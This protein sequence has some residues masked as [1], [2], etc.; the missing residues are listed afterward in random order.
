VATEFNYVVNVDQSRVQSS[1]VELASTMQMALA[2][3]MQGAQLQAP[4]AGTTVSDVAGGAATGFNMMAG[5]FSRFP[6][7]MGGMFS[8]MVGGTFTNQA[9]AYTPHWGMQQAE[10]SLQQEWLVDR[11]GLGAAQRM[12]PPGVGATEFALAV[13]RNFVDRKL[14]AEHAA[15]A[16]ARTTMASGV[17]GIAGMYGGGWIGGAIGKMIGA[18][19]GAPGLGKI[20]GDLVGAIA[21]E[22]LASDLATEH[23][24][25]IEQQQGIMTEL[26]E[27]AGGGLGYTRAQRFAFGAAATEA[28]RSLGMDVQ[29][30]GDIVAGARQMGML[31]SS[32]TSGKATPQQVREDLFNLARSIEEGAEALHTSGAKA[33]QMIRGMTGMGFSSAEG[34]TALVRMGAVS[35]LGAEGIYN[36]GMAGAST[37]RANLMPGRIGFDLFTSSVMAAAGSGMGREEMSMLGGVAGA[38]QLLAMHEIQAARGPMGTLQSM[39]GLTGRSLSGDLYGLG[40]QAIE[41]LNQGGDL[42]SNYVGFAVNQDR[43]AS[44]G[45]AR[46]IRARA[47]QQLET[48]IHFLRDVGVRGSDSELGAFSLIE[49]G[50]NPVQARFLAVQTLG[51]GGGGGRSWAGEAAV[52]AMEQDQALNRQAVAAARTSVPFSNIRAALGAIT[53]VAADSPW[54]TLI[55]S[56]ATG[57]TLGSM[58]PGWGTLVGGLGGL[59]VGGTLVLA[60]R[61]RGE[62][63]LT[64]EQE[65][66]VKSASPKDRTAMVEGF[67]LKNRQDAEMKTVEDKFGRIA[68]DPGSRVD[69]DLLRRAMTGDFRQ[70]LLDLDA[71]NATFSKTTSTLAEAVG[72][73]GRETGGH[74]TIRMG[75][76]YYDVGDLPQLDELGKSAEHTRASRSAFEALRAGLTSSDAERISQMARDFDRLRGDPA[77]QEVAARA[78]AAAREFLGRAGDRYAAQPMSRESRA[79]LESAVTASRLGE[80]WHLD[81]SSLNPRGRRA[82]ALVGALREHDAATGKEIA[83]TLAELVAG[84]EG[85]GFV[86]QLGGALWSGQTRARRALGSALAKDDHFRR[87]VYELAEGTRLR[88]ARRVS[89]GEKELE[90]VVG[91]RASSIY[92]VRGPD[93]AREIARRVERSAGEL[94]HMNDEERRR[95]LNMRGGDDAHRQIL[96][97]HWELFANIN[98]DLLTKKGGA[99]HGSHPRAQSHHAGAA[100]NAIGFG[101]QESAMQHIER[102]L[103]ATRSALEKLN[104]RIP[105]GTAVPP[106]QGPPSRTS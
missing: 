93:V 54:K 34:V 75:G 25:Q 82:L 5:D 28:A 11:Y 92:G 61:S 97:K 35:G 79:I 40:A 36:F 60:G 67:L 9:I 41:G 16:A 6:M 59:A 33:M 77:N 69:R 38:G 3:G 89:A 68:F 30:M 22:G 58:L 15:Y 49:Q 62:S 51:G 87:T 10:T 55:E 23:Y 83:G 71:T 57:A 88:D 46:G 99:L 84:Q 96:A 80:S 1:A 85:Q 2:R 4:F 91:Q 106:P 103:R 90:R 56:T 86:Q 20:A 102:S 47:K 12:K 104:Q 27:I 53:D 72:I 31:P 100:E 39:A 64:P 76:R 63:G 74:G 24:A 50:Y 21:G 45:G 65:E 44:A 17:A 26:G 29:Q 43:Y 105:G 95:M 13:E 101:A 98:E 78:F 7:S 32:L 37:A 18:R 73:H 52:L 70:S 94:A 81:L 42:L 48:S 19:F 14:E 8:P 66:Q